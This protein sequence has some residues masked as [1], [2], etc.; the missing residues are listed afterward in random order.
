[1][2]TF[3]DLLHVVQLLH[4]ERALRDGVPEEGRRHKVLLHVHLLAKINNI[5]H[6]WRADLCVFTPDPVSIAWRQV[7]PQTTSSGP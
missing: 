4:V 7:C 5:K 6:R 1:M 3:H 2:C